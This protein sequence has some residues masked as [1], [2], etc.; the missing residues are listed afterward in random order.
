MYDEQNSIF[1]TKEDL[2]QF[3]LQCR[4]AGIKRLKLN[5]VEV[6]FSDYALASDIASNTPSILTQP[7]Q[8]AV[9][10]E[11]STSKTLVDTEA[12]E[13]DEELLFWSSKG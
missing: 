7:G 3:L 8:G 5:E 9:S 10:E 4:Q 1:E 6:E 11:K 13:A 12:A 2:L